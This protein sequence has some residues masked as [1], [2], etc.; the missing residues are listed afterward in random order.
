MYN[1]RVLNIERASFTPLVFATTG[2]FGKECSLFFNRLAELLSLKRKELY[3][4][5]V[6]HIRTRLRFALL[7][8]ILV[9]VRGV[10][11]KPAAGEEKIETISF[12]LIPTV[13]V[14]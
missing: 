14:E 12:N 5:V 2:G 10:R 13:D 8:A 1:D 3:S 6:A 7:R 11:G 9:A 4:S